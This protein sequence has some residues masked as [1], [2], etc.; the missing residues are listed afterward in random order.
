MFFTSL[1]LLSGNNAYRA[2]SAEILKKDTDGGF[3]Y[4][5]TAA[6]VFPKLGK[7]T[8]DIK[9]FAAQVNL[10]A[11][12]G[13]FK[14]WEDKMMGYYCL[15]WGK[16]IAK[17]IDLNISTS[18]A[19]GS[20]DTG[21]SAAINTAIAPYN[22]LN[23]QMMS[24]FFRQ[25]YTSKTLG[26]GPKFIHK[27]KNNLEV[28]FSAMFTMIDF[29]SHTDYYN[30]IPAANISSKT[31]LD[32]DAKKFYGLFSIWL[33]KKIKLKNNHDLTY[34]IYFE[35]IPSCKLYGTAAGNE[36]TNGAVTKVYSM[37]TEV[38]MASKKPAIGATI[39]YNF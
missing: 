16:P 33:E 24:L 28:N 9:N 22:A 27:L 6:R 11:P 5:F 8:D 18:Y 25:E 13:N 15:I 37:P 29:S 39:K 23:G 7:S 21:K 17:N 38:D 1:V 19:N 30:N 12:V 35:Y 14:T 10:I 20:I 26:I 2:D 31:V 34:G 32:F 36:V 3:Y 4:N